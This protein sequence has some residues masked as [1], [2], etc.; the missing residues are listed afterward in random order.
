[1]DEDDVVYGLNPTEQVRQQFLSEAIAN[2]RDAEGYLANGQQGAADVMLK[3]ADIKA[4]IA[5]AIRPI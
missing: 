2:V 1:M 5:L 4:R 3:L